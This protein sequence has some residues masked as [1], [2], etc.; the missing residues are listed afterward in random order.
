MKKHIILLFVLLGCMYTQ[1]QNTDVKLKYQEAEK[2]FEAGNYQNCISL[3]DETEEIL[4]Q[5]VQNILHLRVM[6]EGKIWEAKPFE[7]Y[8]QVE[9]L[10]NLSN[11][12]LQK[13]DT[14][15]L[16]DVYELSKKLPEVSSQEE[17][18]QLGEQYKTENQDKRHEKALIEQ[19]MVFVEGGTYMMGFRKTSHEVT[20][21]DFYIAKFETTVKQ[22]NKYLEAT[23]RTGNNNIELN[24]LLELYTQVEK[25]SNTAMGLVNTAGK[26]TGVGGVTKLLYD[27]SPLANRIPQQENSAFLRF[28]PEGSAYKKKS[29]VYVNEVLY[30]EINAYCKWLE[31]EYGGTWRLPT[32]AEWEYASRNGNTTE[33]I[34]NIQNKEELNKYRTYYRDVVPVVE[35]SGIT[36]TLAEKTVGRKQPNALGL[37]DMIGN[38]SEL[39]YDY[40]D[41]NYYKNA[42]KDNP[43]GPNQGEYRIARDDVFRS[44]EAYRN[45]VLPR[46]FRVVYIPDEN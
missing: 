37:Y 3:L 20:V 26:L 40:F 34:K 44:A 36:G 17:L 43:M 10:R 11:E 14:A 30:P 18:T 7:S 31:Q 5:S 42:P 33:H 6:A 23:G 13:Y 39:C 22:W 16:S 19:N 9:K 35:M 45:P 32:E 2:A 1:A 27:S 25:V 12:Y 29:L 28:I 38:V 24:R 46:G 21:S 41:K 4:G 15:G 8:E